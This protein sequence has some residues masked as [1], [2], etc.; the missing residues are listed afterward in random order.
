M[1]HFR[2]FLVGNNENQ[3]PGAGVSNS[4]ESQEKAAPSLA[5]V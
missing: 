3:G 5:G 4:L 1:C 2:H